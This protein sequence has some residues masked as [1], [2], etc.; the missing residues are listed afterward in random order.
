MNTPW[1]TIVVP[2]I[3]RPELSRTLDSIDKQ[4]DVS[5]VQVL[6]V[7]D[8][9][10]GRTQELEKARV[11]VFQRGPRYRW[12]EHDGGQH[13]VG[14]PQRQYGMEHAAGQWIAFT[15]DDN[16]LEKGALA[17]I[18]HEVAALPHAM[19]MLFKVRTWQAGVV[20]QRRELLLGNIDADCMVVPNIPEKLG[21]WHNVYAG[22]FHFAEDTATLWGYE[23]HWADAQISLARPGETELWW[24]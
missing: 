13:M 12:L 8:T 7:A 17:A 1:L 22:D 6:V 3:G 20:W 23:L 24:R 19:P 2:T 18:W 15:A 14:Q 16:I 5:A 9:F 4:H 10:G 11:S 21:K